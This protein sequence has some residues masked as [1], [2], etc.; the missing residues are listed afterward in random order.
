MARLIALFQSTH[1]SIAA[2]RLCAEAKVR[3]K[4]IAVPR[5]LTAE[6]GI[7]LE[8]APEQ[9]AAVAD[10]FR[11]NAIPHTFHTLESP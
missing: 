4:T 6:C 1:L 3:C 8:F 2:D 5:T 11:R 7:A 10:L 9:E